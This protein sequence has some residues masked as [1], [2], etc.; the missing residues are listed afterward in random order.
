[1]AKNYYVTT[2]PFTE[3]STICEKCSKE[4]PYGIKIAQHRGEENERRLLKLID[5]ILFQ[6]YREELCQEI[7]DL[8]KIPFVEHKY[9]S[10]VQDCESPATQE[11]LTKAL[12]DARLKF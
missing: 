11:E 2:I 12:V 3:E 7:V 8:F 6:G 4:H 9:K 1:M 5:K 10:I